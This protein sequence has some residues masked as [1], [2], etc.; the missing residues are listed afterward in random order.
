MSI[1]SINGTDSKNYSWIKIKNKIR[2][3]PI[4][5]LNRN[6]MWDAE[7]ITG[8]SGFFETISHLNIVLFSGFIL[9]ADLFQLDMQVSLMRVPDEGNTSG[10]QQEKTGYEL[11]E[12]VY[13]AAN[14]IIKR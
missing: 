3:I 5:Y 13:V 8:R 2:I 4:P 14:N 6:T 9:N 10:T 7:K 1:I 11:L 12:P